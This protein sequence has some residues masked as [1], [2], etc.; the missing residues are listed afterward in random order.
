MFHPFYRNAVFFLFS[1]QRAIFPIFIIPHK[2]F[3]KVSKIRFQDQV[4]NKTYSL[5][6]ANQIGFISHVT[7]L[8]D[9]NNVLFSCT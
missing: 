2:H 8:L 7:V 6:H 9:P 4:V 5:S 3:S 1:F